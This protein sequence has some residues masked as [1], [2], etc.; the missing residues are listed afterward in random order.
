[1]TNPD[2]GNI[3][4]ALVEQIHRAGKIEGYLLALPSKPPAQ[5]LDTLQTLVKAGKDSI[6][7]WDVIAMIRAYND[8]KAIVNPF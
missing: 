7:H 4:T 6:I 8:L 3:L 2:E 5:A 1:M